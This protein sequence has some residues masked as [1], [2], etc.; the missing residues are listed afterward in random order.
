MNRNVLGTKKAARGRVFGAKYAVALLYFAQFSKNLFGINFNLEKSAKTFIAGHNGLLGSSLKRIL[1]ARGYSKLLTRSREELDLTNSNAAHD[2]FQKDKPEYVFITAAKVG[3]IV[4]NR[5]YPADFIYQNLA[6]E[7]NIIHNAYLAGVKKLLFFGS[8]CM[9]PLSAPQ[10][11]KEDSIF[12][13]D[14][15]LTS[16]PYATAK[17][18]GMIMCESYNK[19]YGTKFLTV[20]PNTMYGPNANFDPESSHFLEALVKKF[21][22]AK[23]NNTKVT[24]WGTG[25][26]RREVIYVDDIVEACLLV[27]N[28]E[29][30]LHRANIATGID[31]SIK[32]FAETVRKIVGYEGEIE[33]DISKPDGAKQKLL[34]N[35]KITSLG[36]KPK[37]SL[38][39]GI[40]KTYE[41]F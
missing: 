17:I 16:K 13:G 9:Y 33:W 22:D 32:G 1:E 27:M 20:I 24:L 39:D 21:H 10:P 18:A 19:Q 41:W 40:T 6:I 2:F 25:A 37:I 28:N 15:E 34:D 31:Y 14:V 23:I 38:E 8:S 11:L 29:A 35:S 5:D 4:A 12:T 30:D 36:W 7:T 3:G 26:P